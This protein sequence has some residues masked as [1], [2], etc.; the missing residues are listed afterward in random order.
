VLNW[1]IEN[2]C[3]LPPKEVNG[4]FRSLIAPTLKEISDQE[5]EFVME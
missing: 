4:L 1:W 2:K 5:S 3:P